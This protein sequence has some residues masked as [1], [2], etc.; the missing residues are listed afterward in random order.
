[1]S[2][3]R[4]K[5]HVVHLQV[6]QLQRNELRNLPVSSRPTDL[7]LKGIAPKT[8]NSVTN[9]TNGGGGGGTGMFPSPTAVSDATRRRSKSLKSGSNLADEIHVPPLVIGSA[10]GGRIPARFGSLN[11]TYR[12][13]A[14][15]IASSGGG[16]TGSGLGS[17]KG[18]L[19]RR[20]MYADQ[21]KREMVR[22][23]KSKSNDF[24]D[25]L[26]GSLTGRRKTE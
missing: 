21:I 23:R 25:R 13:A 19:D 4:G 15:S 14:V 9:L 5:K 2:L 6:I 18:S 24:L 17:A 11:A 16:G 8:A 26:E 3:I 10:S 7:R 20:R 12:T 22:S 1:M